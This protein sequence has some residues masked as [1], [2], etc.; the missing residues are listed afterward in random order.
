ML[1]SASRGKTLTDDVVD[2]SLQPFDALL[3]V[4]LDAK[5]GIS[6]MCSEY[7]IDATKRHLDSCEPLTGRIDELTDQTVRDTLAAFFPESTP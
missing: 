1:M 5:S 4:V 3:P 2:R 7:V 6:V